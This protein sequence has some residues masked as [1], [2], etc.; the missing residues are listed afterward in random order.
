MKLSSIKNL[1]AA[2]VGIKSVTVVYCA[3][4][5]A[6][7]H[8][9]SGYTEYGK[10][11]TLWS[12]DKPYLWSKTSTEYDNNKIKDEYAVS[13]I[14]TSA[15]SGFTIKDRIPHWLATDKSTGV[16]ASTDGWSTTTQTITEEKKYLWYYETLTYKSVTTL[17][18]NLLKGTRLL[19]A[20]ATVDNDTC[21]FEQFYKKDGS[22]FVDLYAYIKTSIDY[23]TDLYMEKGIQVALQG[24]RSSESYLPT[25]ATDGDAY[26]VGTSIY[27][28]NGGWEENRQT[29]SDLLTY[30]SCVSLIAGKTYTLSFMVKGQATFYSYLYPDAVVSLKASDGTVLSGSAQADGM[31]QFTVNS[32]SYTRVWVKWIAK[33]NVSGLKNVIIA[34]VIRGK[35]A[36]SLY[37]HSPKL[38]EG[39][40]MSEWSP[41]PDD[42]TSTSTPIII[43]TYGEKGKTGKA[44]LRGPQRWSELPE[45]YQFYCGENS[46]PWSDVVRFGDSDIPYE[47]TKAHVKVSSVTPAQS[48]ANGDGNWKVGQNINVIASWLQLSV[49]SIIENLGVRSIEMKD[50][51]GAVVFTAK[52]GNVTC[53]TGTFDGVTILNALVHGVFTSE[54]TT[55][56]NKVVIDGQSGWIKLYGPSSIN[57]QNYNLPATGATQKELLE[58]GFENDG[59]T[60]K[61]VVSLKAG[62][63]LTGNGVGFEIDGQNGFIIG[64]WTNGQ[65]VSGY[66]YGPNGPLETT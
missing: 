22:Q 33:S 47:C 40:T 46:E 38:E 50:A 55:T 16:T 32:E 62:G 65:R 48:V 26:Y 11:I 42:L 21:S 19:S 1:N 30:P 2:P 6:I 64:S 29:Y 27:V 52:D 10:A 45:G 23:V 53:K 13:S 54:N 51:N 3:G 60:L 7:D 44:A 25:N 20:P 24:T 34:R 39:D 49:Y 61:R 28:Y 9:T 17:G 12:I 66:Q 18:E 37:I 63:A 4:E 56:M 36:A 31:V 8:P 15:L 59:D 14:F 35:S 58:I 57:E 41:N 43:G 5:S